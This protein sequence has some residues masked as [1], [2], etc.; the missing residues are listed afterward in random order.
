VGPEGVELKDLE[1]IKGSGTYRYDSK[2][3]GVIVD[4]LK[5]NIEKK[6]QINDSIEKMRKVI[7]KLEKQKD[8]NE[9]SAMNEP[10][11]NFP[12]MSRYLF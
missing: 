10:M 7:E 5:Q 2:E 12:S 6:Q 3:A 9:P 8:G 4:S 1:K 11:N